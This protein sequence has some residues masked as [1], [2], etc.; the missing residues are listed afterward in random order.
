MTVNGKISHSVMLNCLFKIVIL[1]ALAVSNYIKLLKSRNNLW[2]IVIFSKVE[3]VPSSTLANFWLRHWYFSSKLI[4]CSLLFIFAS[5]WNKALKRIL[6]CSLFM[7]NTTQIKKLT[8]NKSSHLWDF[9][10]KFHIAHAC[11]YVVSQSWSLPF[12]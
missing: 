3:A 7:Q 9:S 12:S 2:D 4:K 1:T 11:K 8:N 10:W 5:A 6:F